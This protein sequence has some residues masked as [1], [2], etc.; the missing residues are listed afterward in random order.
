MKLRSIFVA[1]TFLA[2]LAG[3]SSAATFGVN[4][5]AL[6]LQD[7]GE[8]LFVVAGIGAVSRY[9]LSRSQKFVQV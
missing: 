4:E 1:T 2:G 3:A 8:S 9:K 6:S 5:V 7:E